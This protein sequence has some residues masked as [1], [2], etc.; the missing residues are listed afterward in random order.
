LGGGPGKFAK[1]LVGKEPPNKA[2]AKPYGIAIYQ[3]RIILC[4]TSA[5]CLVVFDLKKKKMEVL[6]PVGEGQLK[7]PI[8]LVVDADG[9][10]YVTDTG[11]GQIV[12][13]S[14]DDTYLGAVGG[15]DEMRPTG[16]A[17]Y[18]DRLLVT[19]LKNNQVRIYDKTNRKLLEAVPK[20]STETNALI[21]PTCLGVEKSGGFYISEMTMGR[22][23]AYSAD[24]R[25]LR[26]IGQLG[27]RPGEFARPKGVAVDRENRVYVVD[28]A[29]QV[30][31][32]FDEQ[33]RLLMYFGGPGSGAGSLDL[34]AGIAVDY[35]HVDLFQAQAAPDFKLEYLVLVTS[36]LG[37]RKVNVYGFGH[38][39]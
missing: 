20:S 4:D 12:I 19:D 24:G 39:K 7:S 36:Q 13:Y 38:K 21:A 34:P 1:F 32:I 10:R 26:T 25:Y 5:R 6:A 18:K 2:I 17:I 27:D 11:R 23:K 14:K 35:D 37:D 3:G 8:N 9:T 15:P 30:V 22:V 29:M 31:Q 33:G 16:L 28:A